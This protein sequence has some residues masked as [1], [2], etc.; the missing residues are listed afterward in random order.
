M[1]GLV[2]T[3]A[4]TPA[5]RARRRATTAGTRACLRAWPHSSRLSNRSTPARRWRQ[6]AT[7][8][9]PWPIRFRGSEVQ[10]CA[11]MLGVALAV[12]G[13]RA[14]P[15]EPDARERSMTTSATHKQ[16]DF[17]SRTTNVATAMIASWASRH[18]R[19]SASLN[20]TPLI[21]IS[22]NAHLRRAD[23][24]PADAVVND[25]PGAPACY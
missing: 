6:A 25:A 24:A 9:P 12:T 1:T 23:S 11:H 13:W 19:F 21:L 3:L 2:G 22:A 10:P 5:L 18:F 16:R 7:P 4:L 8:S 14:P 15:P 20:P 17:A